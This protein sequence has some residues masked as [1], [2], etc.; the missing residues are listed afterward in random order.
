[1]QGEA[2]EDRWKRQKLTNK[3]MLRHI[4]LSG[5]QWPV[6]W[7]TLEDEGAGFAIAD[8]QQ[9]RHAPRVVR[10]NTGPTMS[11]GGGEARIARLEQMVHQLKAELGN[12]RAPGWRKGSAAWSR[13]KERNLVSRCPKCGARDWLGR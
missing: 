3:P 12:R 2:L 7:A 10:H 9:L 4:P 11:E 6:R 8:T 5:M 13:E 1:M